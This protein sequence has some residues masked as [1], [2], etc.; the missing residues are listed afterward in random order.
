MPPIGNLVSIG[1]S[2]VRAGAILTPGSQPPCTEA[3][4]SEG[5][6]FCGTPQVVSSCGHEESPLG[7][8]PCLS[9]E[10]ADGHLPCVACQAR[11]AAAGYARQL[12]AELEAGVEGDDNSAGCGCRGEGQAD[13]DSL[14]EPDKRDSDVSADRKSV[15]TP[16]HEKAQR[17]KVASCLSAMNKIRENKDLFP[18][19]LEQPHFQVQRPVRLVHVYTKEVVI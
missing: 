13:S 2:M 19:D 8:A 3:A 18:E 1:L 15:L 6:P 10:N 11:G 5:A 14:T 12:R 16:Y 7:C 17:A 4:L 9:H